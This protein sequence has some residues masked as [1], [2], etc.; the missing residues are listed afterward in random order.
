MVLSKVLATATDNTLIDNV[1][2]EVFT[3]V[4][5]STSFRNE[6]QFEMSLF[7]VDPRSKVLLDIPTSLL[8]I[9]I[10]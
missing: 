5:I 7:I 6:V 9:T 10:E 2:S 1:F 8:R 3:Q 4:S